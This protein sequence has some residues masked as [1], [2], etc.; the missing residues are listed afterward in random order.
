M[1]VEVSTM[2]FFLPLTFLCLLSPLAA[3][4]IREPQRLHPSQSNP[5]IGPAIASDGN[6]SCA[7]W[8]EAAPT[9]FIWTSV[10]DGRGESWTAPIRLDSDIAQ[11]T[12]NTQL[13]S[14]AVSGDFVY[15][16]WFD[17]RIN[18][19]D[20]ETFF[21][22]S[23]NGGLSWA[24]DRRIDNGYPAGTQAV[25]SVSMA[26]SSP[27]VY[28]AMRVDGPSGN[29]EIW[30][31]ASDD[32]GLSFAPAVYISSLAAGTA[33]A[34]NV[35]ITAEGATC[36]V[37]WCDDRQ[38]F[39]EEEVW[40]Q[41]STDGGA[42][43]LAAD[44]Q[45]DSSPNGTGNAQPGD[46]NIAV[47]GS[48]VA[49]S[50][51]EARTSAVNHEMYFNAS[52]DGGATWLATDVLIG[53]YDANTDDVNFGTMALRDNAVLFAWTDNRTTLEQVYAAVTNDFGTTVNE[54]VI[55]LDDGNT[56]PRAYAWN[57][58]MAITYAGGTSPQD[59][60]V[61]TSRDGGT[62]FSA[63]LS[64]S[65]SLTGDTDLT[66]L[67]FNEFYRNI[68]GVWQQNDPGNNQIYGGGFRPQYLDPITLTA[69]IPA[70]WTGGGFPNSSVGQP[71]IVV[72][73]G[74]TGSLMTPDGRDTGLENGPFFEFTTK[75]SN[76][77]QGTI[78]TDGSATT[79]AI[80]LPVSLIGVTLH[81][82]GVNYEPGVGPGPIT[83]VQTATVM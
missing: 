23:P 27:Y 46:L 62:T 66:A 21:T 10:S 45:L 7:V 79:A 82:I 41:R 76:F 51:L 38:G 6:V 26:T 22:Y 64:L 71:M 1:M 61:V 19:T 29:D 47:D 72:I 56:A 3:Q 12:K 15:V 5:A 69:G 54:V 65:G 48:D 18:G 70:T 32:D 73:A 33:D 58:L 78:Q 34:I 31:S 68:I 39:Q 8:T 60:R 9:N 24:V 35:A 80:T 36:H 14:V 20:S 52:Q 83:T 59:H 2:K 25:E 13:D 49:V 28:L 67:A 53:N 75:P 11:N 30:V 40:Y 16:F 43:W 50:W 55:N 57:D 74:A 42:T 81:M 77:I 63:E 44:V 17:K 4:E 37:T